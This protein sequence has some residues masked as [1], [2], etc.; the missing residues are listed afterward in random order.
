MA[1]RG[2]PNTVTIS[3]GHVEAN[4]SPS[5]IKVRSGEGFFAANFYQSHSLS[6]VLTIYDPTLATTT[7]RR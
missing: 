5:A 4:L 2:D 1:D 7:T 6:E 3:C